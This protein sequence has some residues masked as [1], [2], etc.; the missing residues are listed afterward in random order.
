ME[1]AGLKVRRIHASFEDIPISLKGNLEPAF[2]NADFI[3]TDR[4]HTVFALQLSNGN[5]YFRL[6]SPPVGDYL[7]ACSAAYFEITDTRI[8]PI[9]RC[10]LRPSG[11]FELAPPSFFA[12][13]HY[14]D[15][16]SD[17]EPEVVEDFRRVK[18]SLLDE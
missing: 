9:W 18:K 4:E 6:L 12:L 14:Y 3:P 16:L 13:D 11:T 1:D 8:S 10:R 15:R 2:G 17:G 7:V 5:L